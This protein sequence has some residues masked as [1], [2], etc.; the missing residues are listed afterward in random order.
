MRSFF[1]YYLAFGVLSYLVQRPALL[2][3]VVV[4]FLLRNYIPDPTALFRALTRRGALERALAINPSN[5]VTR[6]D[7]A[8]LYLELRRPAKAIE[9]LAPAVERSDDDAELAYLFGLALHRAGRSAESLP[10]FV[11]AVRDRVIRYGE[12]YRAAGDALFALR[13]FDEA[14]DAYER[15]AETNHSDVAVYASL[16]RAYAADR[17]P[18]ATR[19]AL[20][21]GAETFAHLR[22]AIRRNSIRAHLEVQWLRARLLREMGATLGFAAAV[23]LGGFVV[24]GATHLVFADM[25]PASLWPSSG[26]GFVGVDESALDDPESRRLIEGVERCGSQTT[27]PFGGR[28]EILPEAAGSDASILSDASVSSD[29]LPGPS[30]QG[31]APTSIS[32]LRDRIQVRV[33]YEDFVWVED[34]CLVAVRERSESRLVAEAVYHE[35]LNDPG[36]A[37]IV[38][39]VLERTPSGVRFGASASDEP[40]ATFTQWRPVP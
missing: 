9:V 36:D 19:K 14:I 24:V 37:S 38:T 1:L 27:D 10:Y 32:V 23:A 20:D 21:R 39:I 13:R 29:A 4:I 8:T 31:G 40:P 26:R 12:P 28:Y 2:L 25:G 17:D 7:L 5:V 30:G 33:P 35:D 3:G 11:E 6:R 34:F 15:F 22:G 16:A 18:A